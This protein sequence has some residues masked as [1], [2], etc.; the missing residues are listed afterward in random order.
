MPLSNH[1]DGRGQGN[2]WKAL[3]LVS[4]GGTRDSNDPVSQSIQS[5]LQM[6]ECVGLTR[7]GANDSDT[8]GL[9]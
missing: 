4:G 3:V 1:F 2:A 9:N 7:T 8:Q 6:D 5:A